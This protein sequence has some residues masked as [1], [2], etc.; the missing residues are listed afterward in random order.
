MYS[1]LLRFGAGAHTAWQGYACPNV[2]T[3]LPLSRPGLLSRCNGAEVSF[4]AAIVVNGG[5]RSAKRA[6]QGRY[7]IVKLGS[8]NAE[9]GLDIVQ[10]PGMP[11]RPI[12]RN[13]T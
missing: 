9:S 8:G 12:L 10:G 3:G 1:L 11:V 7:G 13:G 5:H 2:P 6:L 4:D